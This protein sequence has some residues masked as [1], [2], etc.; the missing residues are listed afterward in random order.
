M[1]KA[2]TNPDTNGNRNITMKG[3]PQYSFVHLNYESGLLS[4]MKW[5]RNITIMTDKM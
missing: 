5:K 1:K 4:K 3:P 2:V